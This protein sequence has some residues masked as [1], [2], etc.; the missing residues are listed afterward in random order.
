MDSSVT[1]VFCQTLLC[2]YFAGAILQLGAGKVCGR[3]YY[4]SLFSQF[5]DKYFPTLSIPFQLK[6]SREG[7]NYSGRGKQLSWVQIMI[8][9]KSS[10]PEA[11]DSLLSNKLII[12]PL[13]KLQHRVVAVYS[14][15]KIK[16]L[17]S[18]QT[19]S[20]KPIGRIFVQEMHFWKLCQQPLPMIIFINS[21]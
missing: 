21:P 13:V 3:D 7:V 17:S 1:L 19:S 5:V 9:L 2:G 4:S 6:F 20:R 16:I 8:L 10:A 12:S 15:E 11:P 18:H 14:Q